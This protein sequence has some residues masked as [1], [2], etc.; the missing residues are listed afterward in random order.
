MEKVSEWKTTP[1]AVEK[2]T[3]HFSWREKNVALA[4]DSSKPH[5][6]KSDT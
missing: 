5:H 3:T 4:C 2:T 1:E 6:L